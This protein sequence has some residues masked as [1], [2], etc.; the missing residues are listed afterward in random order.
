MEILSL[1]I[2]TPTVEDD[3]V[4]TWRVLLG[5][6]SMIHVSL[7]DCEYYVRWLFDRPER[8]SGIDLEVVIAHIP[9]AELASAFEKVTGYPARY[10]DTSLEGLLADHVWGSC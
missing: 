4:V 7:N 8:A 5:K 3:G 6:G 9:Y 1:T 10:I 2:I